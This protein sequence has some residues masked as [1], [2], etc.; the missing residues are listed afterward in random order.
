ML[1]NNLFFHHPPPL[2]FT[3]TTTIT[4]NAATII[5]PCPFLTKTIV[6][7]YITDK[8]QETIGSVRS[9]CLMIN[10]FI[11][12]TYPLLTFKVTIASCTH[13]LL[14]T[15]YKWRKKDRRHFV[16]CIS[17]CCCVLTAWL[18]WKKIWIKFKWE[19]FVLIKKCF[20][21]SCLEY[22]I[23]EITVRSE[24]FRIYLKETVF[25]N[26]FRNLFLKTYS[27]NIF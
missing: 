10:V 3:T 20:Y 25:E 14:L 21:F 22:W 18:Q 19:N 16:I 9:N 7:Y 13:Q 12:H 26:I 6:I 2:T 23:M 4:K 1:S 27:N 15:L 11:Y 24:M 8:I 5:S 17:F